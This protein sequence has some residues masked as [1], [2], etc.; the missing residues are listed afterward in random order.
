MGALA[1]VLITAFAIVCVGLPTLL[2]VR[3]TGSSPFRDGPYVNGAVAVVLFAAPFV[4]AAIYELASGGRWL[5]GAVPVVLGTALALLGIAGALQ[6]QLAMG[7][8]WRIGVDPTERTELVTRG[9]Y[10]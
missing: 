2:F 4:A 9:P 10:R 3:S 7:D 5:G 6:A 1:L 8:S